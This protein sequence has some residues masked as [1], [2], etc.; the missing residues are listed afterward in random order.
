M[1]V[2]NTVL[3]SKFAYTAAQQLGQKRQTKAK[4]NSHTH[5]YTF[6][7]YNTIYKR[8]YNKCK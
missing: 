2:L 4:E 1:Y 5:V 6:N 7:G 3:I 8:I